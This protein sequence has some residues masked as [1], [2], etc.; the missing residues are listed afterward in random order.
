MERR[1]FWWKR[2]RWSFGLPRE[3]DIMIKGLVKV[4]YFIGKCVGVVQ[5]LN[6]LKNR[7][8]DRKGKD[9]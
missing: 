2:K 1:Q 6:A 7:R 9:E 5:A 3:G 8:I 4:V